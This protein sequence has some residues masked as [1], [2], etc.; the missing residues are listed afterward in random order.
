MMMIVLVVLVLVLV[1]VVDCVCNVPLL[2]EMRRGTGPL[3]VRG[4]SIGSLECFI[5]LANVRASSSL[6]EHEGGRYAVA[7]YGMAVGQVSPPLRA[8]RQLSAWGSGA[9][10]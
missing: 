5:Y 8:H 3:V 9:H 10:T 1:V 7:I 4:S 6:F 2:I